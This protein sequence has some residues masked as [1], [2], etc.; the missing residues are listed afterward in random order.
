MSLIRLRSSLA[1]AFALSYSCLS[2]IS[3]PAVPWPAFSCATSWSSRASTDP[4]VS[5]CFTVTVDGEN[6]GYFSTCEGLGAEVVMEQLHK[7]PDEIQQAIIE[8]VNRTSLGMA[9][10]QEHGPFV[11]NEEEM[12]DYM[13]QV[14]G[15]VGYMLTESGR[16]LD[17]AV[18]L[19]QRAL[20]IDPG[21]PFYLD[22]LG[23]AYYKAGQFELAE[24]NLRRAAEQLVVNS[25]VQD[26]YGDVLLKLGRLQEA[27]ER[28]TQ[29]ISG[30]GD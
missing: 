11:D 10:W 15:R 8:R 3:A 5:V 29:A 28:W 16:Q 1:A 4:A 19:V 27:I 14:A 30:D 6:L 9:R 25:V 23:W 12:D 13:H 18:R 26:H 22:S 24:E 7:L 21:N 17:E 2:R 20:D